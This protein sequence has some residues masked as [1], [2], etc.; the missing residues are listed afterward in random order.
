MFMVTL[1]KRSLRRVIAVALVGVAACGLWFGRQHYLG[2]TGTAGSAV[3]ITTTQDVQTYFTGY[4]ITID[5]TSLNADRVQVPSTWDDAFVAFNEVV[6]QSGYDLSDVKGETIEKWVASIPDQSTGEISQY[7]V[8]LL[9]DSNIVG[10]YLLE[11]PS[12]EVTGVDDAVV[13]MAEILSGSGMDSGSA[14]SE[15][16]DGSA[17]AS[18]DAEASADVV[19]EQTEPEVKV[20]L[21]VELEPNE[22]GYPVE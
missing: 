7:A 20:S 8:L 9:K 11:K 14:L 3:E 5:Q 6:A 15:S 1:E 13:A 18:A 4:G 12:G 16:G 22:D 21:D 2:N 17:D 19:V 10:A